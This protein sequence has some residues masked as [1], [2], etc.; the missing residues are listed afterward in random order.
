DLLESTSD[1]SQLW[2]SRFV[3]FQ[4]YSRFFLTQETKY[5]EEYSIPEYSYSQLYMKAAI[6]QG[7]SL[8]S[9]PLFMRHVALWEQALIGK[10]RIVDGARLYMK[11]E[12]GETYYDTDPP[13]QW[14]P[15]FS[16]P[17]FRDHIDDYNS[18]LTTSMQETAEYL[19]DQSRYSSWD[20]FKVRRLTYSA[21]GSGILSEE[22]D[23]ELPL[24]LPRGVVTFSNSLLL[25]TLQKHGVEDSEPPLQVLWEDD[26]RMTKG[27]CLVIWKI[28][29]V[30]NWQGLDRKADEV[31]EILWVFYKR[32]ANRIVGDWNL[33]HYQ[34]RRTRASG[35]VQ[36]FVEWL[37]GEV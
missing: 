20:S 26:K 7:G 13:Y 2:T 19:L 30:L 21:C 34:R 27:L 10:I 1:N 31:Q 37:S 11:E 36:D 4:K 17:K 9:F 25:E 6:P 16:I 8:S 15:D 35:D 14:N 18:R 28:N 24:I 3:K 33:L 22:N 12:D 32:L 29:N 23:L 5:D